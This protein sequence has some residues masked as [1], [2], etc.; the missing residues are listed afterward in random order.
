MENNNHTTNKS[1]LYAVGV[2][3]SAGGLDALSRFLSN[4]NGGKAEFC[5]IIVMHL[6]PDYKSE[7]S[8]ILTKRFKW[9]VLT[10]EDGMEMQP[11]QIYVT[12]QNCDV[13]VE[14]NILRLDDLPAKHLSA[15]S[16][17]KFLI[18]LA[19]NFGRQSIGVILSGF[20][21]DGS[22]GISK[23]REK[24]GFTIAQ[25]PKS[26]EH[27]SMP[28]SSIATQNIDAILIAEDMYADIQRFC[29][30]SEFI[31]TSQPKKKDVNVIFELLERRSGTDFSLY[32]PSTIM[33]RINHRINVL[34]LES[35]NDYL[36]Y[37][38]ESPR[39]LDLLFEAVLIGVTEFFRDRLA[40]ENIRKYLKELI[41]SK[42]PGD[43]IR[44]W[45]VGCATGEEPYTISIILH[46]LLG[47]RIRDYQL[48]IFASDLDERAL[49]VGRKGIYQKESLEN[50]PINLLSKYFEKI[51][52][53][54]YVVIKE[55]KQYI[56]FTK[57]DISHDPP[58]VK[59]DMISCRNLLIYFNNDLQ[60]QTLQTFHYSLLPGSL[61]FLGKSES[62]TV[63]ADLFD[64]VSN[65]KVFRKSNSSAS[66]NFR[67]SRFSKNKNEFH[68]YEKERSRS[69]TINDI[70]KE[71]I[72]RSFENPFLVINE[73]A[74]IK[75]V[76]GSVRLYLEIR[77]GS[78]NTNL[79]K[80]ANKEIATILKALHT[81]CKRSGE[82]QISPV[83]RFKLFDEIHHVQVSVAPLLYTLNDI[84]YYI[85]VFERIVYPLKSSEIQEKMDN[86][87]F[88][89][90]RIKELEDELSSTREHLQI[91]TEELEST[92]EELQS[93]NEEMQSSNEELK[94][95]NEELET[96]NEELQSANE[97][98]NTANNELR[99]INEALIEKE[100]ELKKEKEISERNE[101]IYRSIAEN[102]PN[103]TVG[104]LNS[105]FE[106]EYLAGRG[107][108][109]FNVS[110]NSMLGKSL[111]DLNPSA[112]ERD[113]LIKVFS[114]TLKGQSGNIEFNFGENLYN[115]LTVP[116]SLYGEDNRIMYLTQNVTEQR[117]R[118][119][120]LNIA[121]DAA[122]LIIYDWKAKIDI[123]ES[124]PELNDLLGYD[125]NLILSGS[126]YMDKIHK[127][128]HNQ[129]VEQW[130]EALTTGI[131]RY[132]VRLKGE[133]TKWIRVH[134]RLLFDN[135]DNP[136]RILATVMDIT[137]DKQL[138][139]I[140][141]SSEEKF[142][143][144][145]D[146]APV[147]I[148]LTDDEKNINFFSSKWYEFTGCTSA[149]LLN[150]GWKDVVHPQD[151]E[152]VLDV[153]TSNFD[154]RRKFTLEHRIRNHE[155]GYCWFLVHGRPIFHADNEFEGYIG[156]CVDINEQKEFTQ[157]LEELVGQRTAELERSN[158]ELL[159]V[160]MNLEEYAYVASHDLQEPI[161]K[162]RT[163]NSIIRDTTTSQETIEYSDKIDRAASHMTSL[164]KNILDYS[165]LAEAT[166]NHE[167]I[168]LDVLFQEIVDDLDLLVEDKSAQVSF[169]NLGTVHGI[170]MQLLQL[171]SNILK[172][173]LKFNDGI[174]VITI[175]SSKVAGSE[176]DSDEILNT[177]IDYD[178]ITIRDNGIGIKEEY[179]E[180]IF[181]PFKRFS[182][183]SKYGGTG[184]GLAISRRIVELH[185][186]I[187]KVESEVDKGTA[188]N[189]YLPSVRK[190]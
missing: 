68:A 72:Y 175:S 21:S 100:N 48:Q 32:K 120:K 186:G 27:N 17:N 141:Q 164:V 163:F 14:G 96:S 35:I 166:F 64:K 1:K 170:Y 123:F 180:Q 95:S 138:L 121:I 43:T 181:K 105:K 77:E 118:E 86:I 70:A 89:D 124:N 54:R 78:M 113:R 183:K 188:F 167:E 111:P 51:D 83:I 142:R 128:D 37:I 53:N 117:R 159:K 62:I 61:L 185:K 125:R 75:E 144:I 19:E 31:A 153:Y 42:N 157:K 112:K 104:I 66:Y 98:L 169:E 12:P 155:G 127:E 189:I 45:S 187:I 150:G 168:E 52:E 190:R 67:F 65:Y 59:L 46:E 97:E 38:K 6:S 109:R 116:L 172:N 20:G 16:I 50:L 126:M 99:I 94:S 152:H 134:G 130:N 92:N 173:S 84:Q 13:H 28:T 139:S 143:T 90:I 149:E 115:L 165:R 85:V 10:I 151:R 82:K 69:M 162:I 156:T 80:M 176:I 102:I 132:E 41:E 108:D 161:R 179:L 147:M 5:V 110:A 60:K 49:Q 129:I 71:T 2:G 57:H 136:E 40:F 26:A 81:Q 63:A 93:I 4:F 106:I 11:G 88:T 44:V 145:A 122:A 39:E 154:K 76:N 30:N 55:L 140:L 101:V 133:K 103:G 7:L 15:P 24:G 135:E 56:L 8:N 174:P 184:I 171:F 23:I 22:E 3:A 47:K 148:W 9:P 114:E 25:V 182:S 119:L 178:L 137:K 177:K 87:D 33:R 18:S 36:G 160:N 74:E 146:S 29:R 107:L 73:N 91:F 79:Y 131:I 58:F 158:S 34:Q